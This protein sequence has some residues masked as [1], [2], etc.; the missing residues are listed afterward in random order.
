MEATGLPDLIRQHLAQ[1]EYLHVI[2][3]PLPI[4]GLALG[5]LAMVVAL[6][7]RTRSAQV[8]ALIIV[9]V[10]AASAWPVKEFGEQGFDRVE[11]LSD[12]A[13][14]RWLDAHAQRATRAMPVFYALSALS[15]IALLVPWKFPKAALPLYA[16]TLLLTLVAVG[17]GAWIGYA[18]GPVRHKEFRYGLPTEP[19]GGYEKMR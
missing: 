18:G 11:S 19:E 9:F 2:L 10:S 13:G 4:Y 5:V 7:L 14:Y 17:I 6:I 16:L 1:P 3:N 8:T 15:L 12:S